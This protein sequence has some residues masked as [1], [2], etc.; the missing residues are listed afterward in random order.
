[1]RAKTR[2]ILDES[3]VDLSSRARSVR[4][5]LLY[6]GGWWRRR[7]SMGLDYSSLSPSARLMDLA[8]VGCHI[9]STRRAGR[10]EEIR[11]PPH[12]AAID[13]AVD[14]LPDKQRQEVTRFYMRGW[15]RRPRRTI[16]LKRA[17]DAVGVILFGVG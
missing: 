4:Q 5:S 13:A 17:E 6:W 12:I 1:M 2:Q 14:A 10:S 15:G 3:G 7:E 16:T 9:Q 8:R 11:V